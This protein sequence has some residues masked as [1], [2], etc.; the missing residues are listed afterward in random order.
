MRERTPVHLWIVGGLAA[1]W[2][3]FGCYDYT[4]TRMRNTDY[5]ASMMPGVDP[6]AVL[7]WVD[8]F[9]IWVAFGW[10]LG[11]WMGLAAALLLLFRSRW[12]VPAQGLSLIGALLGLGYQIMGGAE[13]LPGMEDTMVNK[14]MPFIIIAIALG[15]FLYARAMA[16]RGVLK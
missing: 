11:V 6:Q 10:G 9:P 4:M 13:P 7:N 8:G 3:A 16:N 5:I 15:L 12:A 2:G 1:L 14:L